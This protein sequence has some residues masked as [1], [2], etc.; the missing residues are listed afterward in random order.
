[1]TIAMTLTIAAT[2]LSPSGVIIT[3]IKGSFGRGVAILLMA[4]SDSLQTVVLK[5]VCTLLDL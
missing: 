4:S 5:H 2:P 3:W 1:M